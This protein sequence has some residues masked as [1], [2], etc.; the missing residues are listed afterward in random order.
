MNK[1][2]TN[3]HEIISEE[4]AQKVFQIMEK[5][6]FGSE[7]TAQIKHEL[8]QEN[9]AQWLDAFQQNEIVA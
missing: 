3:Q 9:F 7:K 2:T 5:H 4:T 8:S 1:P 6:D